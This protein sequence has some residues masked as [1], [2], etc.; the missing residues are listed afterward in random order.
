M[1]ATPQAC[2][3]PQ[4]WLVATRAVNQ[5]I[6]YQI[7]AILID[8]FNYQFQLIEACLSISISISCHWP[9]NY[10]PIN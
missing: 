9:F 10:G 3:T 2:T 4:A 7:I 8:Y 1:I 6:N 5:L